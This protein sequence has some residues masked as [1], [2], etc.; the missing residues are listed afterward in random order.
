M[1]AKAEGQVVVRKKTDILVAV[2]PSSQGK[3]LYTEGEL[4]VARGRSCA[5]EGIIRSGQHRS[6][7]P[8]PFWSPIR[9]QRFDPSVDV[10]CDPNMEPKSTLQRLP[11]LHPLVRNGFLP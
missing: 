8:F 11:T 7:S 10:L 1:K 9:R 6:S 2:R 5:R 3:Y 4:E